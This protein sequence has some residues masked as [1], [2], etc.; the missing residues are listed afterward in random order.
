MQ[1]WAGDEALSFEGEFQDTHK[2]ADRD[3]RDQAM[4][5]R[6]R[7]QGRHAIRGAPAGLLEQ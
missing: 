5:S 4:G 6:I 3:P 2:S 7:D 1:R